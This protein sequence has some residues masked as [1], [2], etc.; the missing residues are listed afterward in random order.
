MNVCRIQML[1]DWPPRS[2]AGKTERHVDQVPHSGAGRQTANNDHA[3]AEYHTVVLETPSSVRRSGRVSKERETDFVF[4]PRLTSFSQKTTVNRRFTIAPRTELSAKEQ[5]DRG[6]IDHEECLKSTTSTRNA[7][8]GCLQHVKVR[9]EESE[10][11]G[12][13][14]EENSGELQEHVNK[15]LSTRWLKTLCYDNKFPR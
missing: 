6:G 15:T 8:R 1:R 2:S 9:V 11:Q 4:S 3:V 7:R 5:G 10:R 12:R 14:L 13:T